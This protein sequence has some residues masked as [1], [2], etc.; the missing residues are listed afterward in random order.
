MNDLTDIEIGELNRLVGGLQHYRRVNRSKWAYYDGEAGVKN[1]GIAIPSSMVNI[2]AILAW[3][4][5]VVDALEERLDW[6]G[7][8][9]IGGTDV[10]GM[11]A[12]FREQQLGAEVA[13]AILEAL[14]TGVGF[15]EVSA[16]G[17][18]E[19]PVQVGA[20]P[21]SRATFRWDARRGRMAAGV[22]VSTGDR[23]ERL[24]TLYLPDETVTVTRSGNRVE[25]VSRV[26]HNR[27]RCGLVVLANR[28]RAGEIRGKS[29]LTPAIRYYT[30][31]AVRTLLEMEYNREIY[32]TPQRYFINVDP[33]EL[34][35]D[36][37]S[38]ESGRALQ[39]YRAAM[40]HAT[41]IPANDEGMPEPKLGQF[42]SAPPTP[43]IEEVK[44]MGQHVAAAA[45]IP[46]SYLGFN[47]DNPPSADAI[48][49]LE[50]RLIKKAERRQA[51]FGEALRNDLGYIVASILNGAPV[52]HEF[53]GGL[54]VRWRNAATPT[55]AASADAAV[56]LAGSQI[57]PPDSEVLLE[58]LGLT[59][60]D[61]QR[62]QA[63]RVRAQAL[64]VLADV[65]AT[66]EAAPQV[67]Q[68]RPV[69][70]H[71]GEV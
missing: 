28:S 67:A 68:A 26:T 17:T 10:T 6:L 52:E 71:V 61:Q 46:V 47:T 53:V 60:E 59:P 12:V 9:G 8:A 64:R 58:M 41:A 42:Q 40:T 62:V 2:T 39:A 48:R 69:A 49:A 18:G 36:A 13:K 50:A 22:V 23:G 15:V 35:M 4:E 16:G 32:T 21:A 57:I 19:L 1:M 63:D 29:E 14:V 70:A 20:V 56:K 65:R 37:D 24:E 55:M 38:S 31:H 34:G 66:A 54:Q 51:I 5:I 7:W 11:Q 3:P 27:G 33:G 25:V 44:M 45:G 30:D 43:Y